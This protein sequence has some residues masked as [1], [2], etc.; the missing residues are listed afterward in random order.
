MSMF[1]NPGDTWGLPFLGWSLVGGCDGFSSL[2][3]Q[4][5]SGDVR[6]VGDPGVHHR[7][8]CVV[9]KAFQLTDVELDDLLGFWGALTSFKTIER[10]GD[11]PG[12]PAPVALGVDSPQRSPGLTCYSVRAR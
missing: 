3:I 1:G 5:P 10:H 4:C 6:L 8:L 12:L 7:A 2:L 11:S 9:V